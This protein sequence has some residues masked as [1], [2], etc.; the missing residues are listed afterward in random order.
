M[1]RHADRSEAY[2][3]GLVRELRALPRETEWIEFKENNANPQEIGEYISALANSAALVG[4]PLA[5][6][7]WGVSDGDHAIVG[8]LF[9]PESAKNG[10]EAL[11]NWLLRLISPKIQFRFLKVSIDGKPVIIL[12]IEQAFRHPVQFQSQEF[13][14]V[15]NHK[16]KLKDHPQKEADLWRAFDTTPF[17]RAIAV[18][19]APDDDVLRLLAYPSY[20]DLLNQQLPTDRGGI[21]NALQA[22][23]IIQK[24]EAGGWDITNL[25]AIL[26]AKNL[27]DFPLLKR[28]AVRVIVYRGNSRIETIREQEGSKGYAAGF[29]GLIGFING[30]L[31]SNEIISQAIR[32]TVPVFPELAVRELVANALIHQ[33]LTIRGAG[34]MVELF[35]DRIEITNPG[36]P[37]VATDRFVDSPPRSRNEALASLM[38]RM[39]ICEERGTGWDKV[40]AQTEFYQLRAPVAEVA[41]ES[42]RVTLLS[43]RPLTEMDKS[44]RINAMY[45]HAVLKY[46]NREP[47]TNTTVRQRFGI[48]EQNSASASRLIREAVEA[49]RIVPFDADA[50]PKN[51]RY[52][53]FWAV[54]ESAPNS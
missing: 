7:V 16:K 49:G 35:D 14:R 42:T 43:P 38:R 33:D 40:V 24:S 18:T 46:V 25:G 45:W 32:K 47:V 10:N 6:I 4:K 12:E 19:N 2:L 36:A 20:F 23:G 53:P 34:P 51:M 29:E 5:Y 31:P 37:L 27:H 26:F 11:E 21:L 9:D 39:G 44:E 41:G 1:T 17:E 3:S 48:E 30:L 15:G 54:A 8:T 28:K 22:D 50:A 13:I 52:R